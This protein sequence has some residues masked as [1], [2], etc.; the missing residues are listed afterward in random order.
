M[1]G[2]GRS[3][4][5]LG[6]VLV[7]PLHLV[8]AGVSVLV[9]REPDLEVAGEAATA[10]EALEVL[11]RL[12]RRR[13]VKVVVSLSLQGD[14]DAYALIREIR[15]RDPS[16]PILTTG[17]GADGNAISRALFAG[18]DGFLDKGLAPE[19]F[20][21]ALR[22][23]RQGEMVLEGVPADWLG[24]IADS[25]ERQ[26]R[27]A[28]F[29]TGRELEVLSVAAE[30]LTARQIGRRLGIAER[31]ITTHLSRIYGKLGVTSRTA[32]LNAAARSGLVAVAGA[33]E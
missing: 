12:A 17:A 19:R 25:L 31:T 24:P 33:A 3:A 8:R 7:E 9:S 14:L 6:V 5:R 29:L 11:R 13:D 26:R 30:G 20:L 2:H 1:Q 16:L 10:E 15:E 4:H 27:F 32:A 18:A 28:P 23:A 22:R 21:E